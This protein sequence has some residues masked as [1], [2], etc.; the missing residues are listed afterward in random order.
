MTAQFDPYHVWLGIPPGDQPPNHYRLL[1]LAPFETDA[2]VIAH[3]AD[4]QMAHLKSVGTSKHANLAQRLLNE[5]S[6]AKVCLLRPEKKAAYD[7]S[8]RAQLA[9]QQPPAPPAGGGGGGAFPNV[10]PAVRRPPPIV[11]SRDKS[12][13]MLWAASLGG[14]VVIGGLI[15]A[16]N[17]SNS[18][19]EEPSGTHVA[20]ATNSDKDTRTDTPQTKTDDGKSNVDPVVESPVAPNSKTKTGD[21]TTLP[22]GKSPPDQEI[23]TAP[24]PS[25]GDNNANTS[26]A[27][28]SPTAPR[29]PVVSLPERDAKP[30]DGMQSVAGWQTNGVPT[31]LLKLDSVE[32]RKL[33]PGLILLRYPRQAIQKQE[34]GAFV[35]P[36]EL[37]SPLGPPTLA[38]GMARLHYPTNENVLAVGYVRIN[39]AGQYTIGGGN[40]FGR[41]TVYLLG[42]PLVR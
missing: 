33:R 40:R 20:R 36:K 31:A 4:R 19:D 17:Y 32:A 18:K 7:N 29:F 27:A 34:P 6:A 5:C 11:R 37:G 24:P 28:R 8:L 16:L 22:N 42:E 13:S 15:A 9:S 41:D 3:A 23:D 12:R 10:A 35:L 2:N 39:E 26:A 30:F 38:R 14:L 21:D 1:G 25:T